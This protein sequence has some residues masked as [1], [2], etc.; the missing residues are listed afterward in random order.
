LTLGPGHLSAEPESHRRVLLVYSFG[1]HFAP[2]DEFATELKRELTRISPKPVEFFEASLETA[3]FPETRTESALADYLQALFQESGI[4]LVISI[5]GPAARFCFGHRDKLFPTTPLLMAGLEARVL[6]TAPRRPDAASIAVA[7]DIPAAIEHILHVLPDTADIAVV[8]GG[9]SLDRLWVAGLRRELEPFHDRVRFTFL[10]D[11][12]LEE[13]ETR[14]AAL[15]LGTAVLYGLVSVDGAGVPHEHDRA[16][17]RLRAVSSAPIFGLFDSQ[18]GRGIVGGPLLP[19]PE[20]S[21]RAA[22][23]GLRLL[24][25]E[26]PEA[27]GTVPLTAGAPI[28]DYRELL[29]F[30]IP[31]SRLPAGST[32]LFRPRS[33]F[34]RYRVPLFVG[35]S[36][37]GLEA[38]LIAG[39]LLQRARRHRAE[40]AASDLSQRLLTA[41]E[42]ERRRLAQEL[43]DDLSQRLARLAIDAAQI[44]RH[45]GGTPAEGLARSMHE[46]SVRLS[47]DVH[48]LSYRLH[49]SVLDD[50]GLSEALRTECDLFS[51]RESIRAELTASELPAE[52]PPS[53]AICL[54]RIAQEALNNVARHAR[55]SRVDLS[56]TRQNGGI[57]LTVNDDGQGF[58]PA[59]QK[60][61][62]LGHASMRERIRLVQGRL[63]IQSVPGRGTTVRAWVPASG[64]LP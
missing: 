3:R 53:A 47:D 17:D 40:E 18:L 13:I 43:H 42:D 57:Q 12:P 56:L 58:Q 37:M 10:Y 35:L 16:L 29:R 45:L 49:P 46:D 50:L 2:F 26:S 15:P 14:V 51:R 7:L 34:A 21:R 22:E 41:H 61:R 27:I 32:V 54:F 4:D 8:M 25:G 52:L 24:E 9:S 1:A 20:A 30:G 38:A 36:V 63:D 59:Q 33:F 55:A 28:Y 62:S 23:A 6:P 48:A 44:E 19:I 5:G 60:G 39:L 31:E 11:V 64:A